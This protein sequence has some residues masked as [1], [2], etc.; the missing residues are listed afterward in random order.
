M[1]IKNLESGT[2]VRNRLSRGIVL[3]IRLLM[4]Q[5]EPNEESFDKVAFIIL[6]LEK[7][8]ESVDVSAI[9]W[10]KRDFWMKADAFRREWEW[11]LNCAERLQT[12]LFAKNWV[13]VASELIVVGQKLHKIQISPKNRIGEPWVGAWQVLEKR[14][15]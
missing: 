10:E 11:S 8:Y 5:G 14:K 7:I 12:A 4:A 6:A 2:T 3:A 15:R 13:D 9:A 1:A